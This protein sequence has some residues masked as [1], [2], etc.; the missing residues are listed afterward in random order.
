MFSNVDPIRAMNYN[1]PDIVLLGNTDRCTD[2][3]RTVSVNMQRYFFPQNHSHIF[4]AGIASE[5][6]T[7]LFRFF[8]LQKKMKK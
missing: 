7:I 6:I 3:I 4:L 2:I 5:M 1:D 8:L